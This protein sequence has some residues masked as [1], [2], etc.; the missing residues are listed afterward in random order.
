MEAVCRFSHVVIT[1]SVAQKSL[2]NRVL[3]PLDTRVS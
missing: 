3:V 1:R 2:Y